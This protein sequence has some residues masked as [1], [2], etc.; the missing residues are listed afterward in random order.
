MFAWLV[1][2]EDDTD[3]LVAAIGKAWSGGEAVVARLTVPTK[4]PSKPIAVIWPDR[5][6]ARREPR[7][8]ALLDDWRDIYEEALFPNAE[9][10][11]LSEELSGLG[12][13]SLCVHAGPGL[14][15]GTVAWFEQGGLIGY[16][17][18]GGAS[19]SWD[20]EEGLGRPFDGTAASIAALGG[21]RVAKL[22]GSERDIDVFERVENANRAVGGVLLCRAFYRILG[23]DP[24]AM[25]DLAGLV[26][27]AG[28][29]RMRC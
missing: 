18:V 20:P 2:R 4:K 27:K 15:T 16:E 22:F 23:Q 10:P 13:P 29:Q 11:V 3:V 14:A 1:I 12:A 28:E 8:P 5:A 25:D 24:P 7:W 17:H 9:I 6:K 26:A 19:V 21:K